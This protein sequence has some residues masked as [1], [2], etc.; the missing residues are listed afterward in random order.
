ML[1]RLCIQNFVLI[2][3]LTV[4]FE[5]GFNVLTGETGAGKTALLDAIALILGMRADHSLIRAGAARA[6]VEAT[7]EVENEKALSSLLNE[8]AL[9]WE[10]GEPLTIVRELSLSGKNRA[11]IN[12]QTTTLP[13][14]QRV[15]SHLIALFS[16]HSHQTLRETSYHRHLLDLF[17]DLKTEVA[18]FQDKW[19]EERT[20]AQE[21]LSAK[22]AMQRRDHELSYSSHVIEEIKEAALKEG[23]EESLFEE[24]SRLSHL[25]EII[26]TLSALQQELFEAQDSLLSRLSFWNHRLS[27]LVSVDSRVETLLSDLSQAALHLSE[28]SFELSSHLSGCE[29]DPLRKEQLEKRLSSIDRIKKKYGKSLKEI[30]ERREAA[31]ETVCSYSTL[32]ERLRSLEVQEEN[33]KKEM[34][35]RAQELTEKRRAAAHRLAPFVSE[36]LSTLNMPDNLFTIELTPLERTSQG[37]EEISFFLKANQGE[38]A[39]SVAASISGGELARLMLAITTLLA[40]KNQTETLLFDEI[41]ANIGGETAAKIGMRLKDLGKSRQVICVTHFPQVAK[42]AD[43][44][45]CVQKKSA[46]GR[47]LA[48]AAKLKKR[49][50]E[51]ELQ[52]MLGGEFAYVE[53]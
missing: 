21:I 12:G 2:E 52:R 47:T 8:A 5:K 32:E 4:D 29:S 22:E 27:A 30:E 42:F 14:L 41:D 44:H 3:S 7:F 39:A 18:H 11:F 43:A 17:G 16:Q 37:E 46:E 13:L 15:G 45:F 34:Q 1:K 23:E 10:S 33:L 38:G 31:E 28:A 25:S 20:L 51:K 24:Y 9:F 50:K 36:A 48:S 6:R 49:E 35:T 26:E 53:S 40:E 19:D